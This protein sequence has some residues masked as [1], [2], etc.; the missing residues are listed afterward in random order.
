M[1]LPR[2]NNCWMVTS[3]PYDLMLNF[4]SAYAYHLIV[5]AHCPS[6]CD[7][8]SMVCVWH[9]LLC[10]SVLKWVLF[11]FLD[12]FSSGMIWILNMPLSVTTRDRSPCWSWSRTPV[13]LSRPSRDMKVGSAQKF[14]TWA[15]IYIPSS[16]LWVWGM[17]HSLWAA[18]FQFE[19]CML[20]LERKLRVRC[21]VC[22]MH[23]KSC[24]NCSN[25]R[26]VLLTLFTDWSIG[27]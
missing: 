4:F 8:R 18:I 3:F 13:P 9:C 7:C 22:F 25:G 26:F 12:C 11:P 17:A 1:R 6:H 15:G 27:L 10:A 21:Q 14:F 19:F 5:I 20:G 23:Q 16:A 24:L 2:Y